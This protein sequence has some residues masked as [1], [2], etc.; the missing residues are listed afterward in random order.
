MTEITTTVAEWTDLRYTE[1]KVGDTGDCVA[2]VRLILS[3][4]MNMDRYVVERNDE[5]YDEGLKSAIL[6]YQQTHGLRET[7]TVN[8]ATLNVLLKDV[9]NHGNQIDYEEG[10]NDENNDIIDLGD[11]IDFKNPHFGS[12]FHKNNLKT[13]RKNKNEIKISLGNGAHV[14]TIHDV[15][16]RSVGVEFDTSGNPIS[17]V[18]EFIARDLTENDEPNDTNKYV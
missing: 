5:Y 4:T 17:E 2:Q 7:G 16:M 1:L 18:Y 12:F 10:N 13:T 3:Y 14:K 9:K 6:S 11:E 8:D 15:Y